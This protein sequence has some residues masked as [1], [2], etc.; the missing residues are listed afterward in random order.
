MTF[1]EANKEIGQAKR[2]DLIREILRK[3]YK[4]EK[5]VTVACYSCTHSR[6]C[7]L[8]KASRKIGA[9][10]VCCAYYQKKE[11]CDES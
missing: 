9:F 5:A 8:F 11:S 7:W 3:D 2:Q 4:V 6:P 10:P 1:E